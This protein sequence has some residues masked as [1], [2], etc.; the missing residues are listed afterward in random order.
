MHDHLW[1]TAERL[2]R[3]Q[4]HTGTWHRICRGLVYTCWNP[5]LGH[6][7]NQQERSVLLRLVYNRRSQIRRNYRI[8]RVMCNRDDEYMSPSWNADMIACRLCWCDLSFCEGHI[9]LRPYR[10]NKMLPVRE[11]SLRHFRRK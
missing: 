8:G 4:R 11:K 6:L 7:I 2:Q 1:Q 3:L 10:D 5:I 9:T